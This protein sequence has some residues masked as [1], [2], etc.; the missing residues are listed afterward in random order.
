MQSVDWDDDTVPD[1]F[2]L[3]N[4]C[5]FFY[6]RPSWYAFEVGDQIVHLS[7]IGPSA[8][9]VVRVDPCYGPGEDYYPD[10]V[11]DYRRVTIRG[12]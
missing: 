5:A 1:I 4:G 12:V 7:E 8:Y 6:D 2:V 11:S 10:T 9:R 3:D